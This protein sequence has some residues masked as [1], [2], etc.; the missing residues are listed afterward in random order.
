MRARSHQAVARASDALANLPVWQ[1]RRI[2]FLTEILTRMGKDRRHGLTLSETID[3]I[4]SARYRGRLLGAF[5][6]R[7]YRLRLSSKSLIRFWYMWRTSRQPQVFVLKYRPRQGSK[8][9]PALIQRLVRQAA[10]QGLTLA[11]LCRTVRLPFSTRT[12]RRH[13]GSENTFRLARIHRLR[14][15]AATKMQAA[16][17]EAK[18]F[19]FNDIA[20]RRSSVGRRGK[21]QG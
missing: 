13:V 11:G 6:R 12:L 18:S 16:V 21:R 5:G 7:R 20:S 14:R 2:E 17:D 15:Q 10:K 9:P 4:R 8:V 1:R 3:R 19:G